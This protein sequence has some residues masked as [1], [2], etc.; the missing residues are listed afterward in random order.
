[1][2]EENRPNFFRRRVIPAAV[3]IAILF[4]IGYCATRGEEEVEPVATGTPNPLVGGFPT[5]TPGAEQALNNNNSDASLGII[6]PYTRLLYLFAADPT[7]YEGWDCFHVPG[8]GNGSTGTTWGAVLVGGLSEWT[9]DTTQGAAF[10]NGVGQP[11]TTFDATTHPDTWPIEVR[12][13]HKGTV[14]CSK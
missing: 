6:H 2:S 13:V 3:A 10:L 9:I 8:E 14:V 11:P 4:G 5:L 1:M 12:L 7:G